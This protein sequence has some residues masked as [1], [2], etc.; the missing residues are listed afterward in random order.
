M[1]LSVLC[2]ALSGNFGTKFYFCY[3]PPELLGQGGPQAQNLFAVAAKLGLSLLSLPPLLV[4][5]SSK[6]NIANDSSE[7]MLSMHHSHPR[8][9]LEAEKS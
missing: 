6:G 7:D 9:A 1:F 8:P 2:L 3:F 5:H 4:I